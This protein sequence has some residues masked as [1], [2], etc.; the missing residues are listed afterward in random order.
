MHISVMMHYPVM[1]G[2]VVSSS[3]TGQ[4]MTSTAPTPDS[5]STSTTYYTAFLPITTTTTTSVSISYSASSDSILAPAPLLTPILS[6]HHPPG[7]QPSHKPLPVRSPTQE[8]KQG[9]C[10]TSQ[11]AEPKDE[12][13]CHCPD[14]YTQDWILVLGERLF[15]F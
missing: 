2:T 14:T 10:K 12:W 11:V 1:D 7:P 13:N 8:E 3:A 4:G 9:C 15:Y 5:T 6:P